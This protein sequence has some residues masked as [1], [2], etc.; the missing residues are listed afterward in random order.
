[1]WIDPALGPCLYGAEQASD[2]LGEG[3]NFLFDGG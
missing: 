3:D 2:L 1:V